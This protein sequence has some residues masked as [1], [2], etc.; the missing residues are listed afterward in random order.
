VIIIPP[1]VLITCS[2]SDLNFVCLR[3]SNVSMALLPLHISSLLVEFHKENPDMATHIRTSQSDEGTSELPTLL[4]PTSLSPHLHHLTYMSNA[5]SQSLSLLSS[6]AQ[7]CR[8]T[9]ALYEA[10]AE[11]VSDATTSSAIIQ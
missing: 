7:S 10:A 2:V 1:V 11:Q 3:L 6:P 5:N 9:L 4:P 8:S